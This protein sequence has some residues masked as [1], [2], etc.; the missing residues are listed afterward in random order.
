MNP[1]IINFNERSTLPAR[2]EAEA[3]KL[4]LSV[5]QLAMR[6]LAEGIDRAEHLQGEMHPGESQD[7]F[8]VINGLL[9]P[10]Q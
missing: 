4:S 5:E 9:N 3:E 1:L 7:N 6:Y 2:L 10:E 8:L